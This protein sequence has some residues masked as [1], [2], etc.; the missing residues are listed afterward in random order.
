MKVYYL[1]KSLKVGD[2]I[3]P[4]NNSCL[5]HVDPFIRALGHSE[6]C[7]YAMV[8]QGKYMHSVF[9]HSGLDMAWTDYA[10]WATEAVFEYIRRKEFP[11]CISRLRCN[12]YYNHQEEAK[13]L[14][15]RN[16]GQAP[17]EEGL[18][19]VYEIEL[20]EKRPVYYDRSIFD[21]AYEIMGDTQELDKVLRTARRYFAGKHT[22]SPMLELLSEKTA[23]VMA[24]G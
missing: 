5:S 22:E 15:R 17:E 13:A 8:L 11:N 14:L 16:D 1:G 10:R 4:D 24:K 18:V 21:M 19:Q 12:F 20:D 7:F 9:Q 3:V 2:T 6:D 23:T